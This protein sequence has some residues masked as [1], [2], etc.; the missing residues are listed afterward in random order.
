MLNK[1]IQELIDEG[2]EPKEK[3][4]RSGKF[5]PSSFGKC[6]RNQYWN[7]LDE[8][9]S[10]LIDT[11][12]LRVFKAGNL[13]H[14]FVEGLLVD[15]GYQKEQLIETEDIKGFCDLVNTD[16]VADIKSQHSKAFWYMSK[17]QDI[18]ED[19]KPNWLQVAWYA[20]ELNKQY[21]RLV[22]VSKD[23][24]CIQEYR[25]EIDNY[26]KE[27][28]KKEL[29]T[30]RGYWAK[31]ELP[32]AQPR[33]YKQKDGSFKECDYCNFRDKCFLMEGKKLPKTKEKK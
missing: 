13:F 6:F 8:P 33:C 14:D 16:E 24:L 21:M 15:K 7:R 31:K 17:T 32:S 3:R 12:T 22:F 1:S 29:D 27:E 2:L 20:I 25:L 11:R 9:V 28:V 30:L 5:S 23:D 4:V 18:K 10:N 26:W 19:K